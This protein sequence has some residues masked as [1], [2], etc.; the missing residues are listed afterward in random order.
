MT[1]HKTLKRR[2]RA[3]SIKTGESYTAARAQVLRKA[4]APDPPPDSMA[5]AGMSDEAMIRGTGKSLSEWFPL[6]DAW[7]ATEHRHPEVARWLVNEHGVAGWWAQNVTVAY[8]RA[9]GIRVLH[10]D[11]AGFSISVSKTIAA[12]ADRVSDAF[13][14]ASLR[15]AWLPDAPIRLR[16]ST[17]GRSARFDW[18]DPSSL[19]GVMLFAKGDA[20]TQVSLGHE[21]LP[22]ADAADR[23][24][25]MWRSRLSALKAMLEGT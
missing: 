22:D 23:L 8:E 20:R 5:L 9:R 4:E 1:T 14:D 13:T 19:I 25:L 2:V 24:K 10:Q 3:R 21:K 7:G 12:S 16:R 17:R 18:D 11:P 15:S 6:L